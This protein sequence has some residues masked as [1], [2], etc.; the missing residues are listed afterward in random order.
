VEKLSYS[1][2]EILTKL[3]PRGPVQP[4]TKEYLRAMDRKQL[5]VEHVDRDGVA[6]PQVLEGDTEAGWWARDLVEKLRRG[7]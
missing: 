6:H 3:P 1:A 4:A 7:H 2:R 5:I